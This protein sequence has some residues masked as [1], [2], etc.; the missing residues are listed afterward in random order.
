MKLTIF[1]LLFFIFQCAP[2]PEKTYS[3]DRQEIEKQARANELY[4]GNTLEK[5]LEV[6][7]EPIQTIESEPSVFYYYY[8]YIVEFQDNVLT[9]FKYIRNLGYIKNSND[10]L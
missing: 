5:F 8:D 2:T 1:F 4:K 10:S 7:G 9:G 3:M 6:F